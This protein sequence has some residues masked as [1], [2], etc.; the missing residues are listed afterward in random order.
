MQ[1]RLAT[2]QP[3]RLWGFDRN[4]AL[5]TIAASWVGC[6]VRKQDGDGRR[7]RAAS[8]QR[9]FLGGGRL[10]ANCE[11]SRGRINAVL[12]ADEDGTGTRRHRARLR[13]ATQVVGQEVERK[14]RQRWATTTAN[15]LVTSSQLSIVRPSIVRPTVLGIPCVRARGVRE[16]R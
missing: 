16:I 12:R 9:Q 15:S 14:L 10:P 13:Q 4:I 2:Q 1:T 7:R 8:V 3:G 5:R 11:A 6:W